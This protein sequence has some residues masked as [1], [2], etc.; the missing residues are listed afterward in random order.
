MSR[1]ENIHVREI[2]ALLFFNPL[3]YLI[4]ASFDGSS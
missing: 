2:T 4:T 3:K 1:K